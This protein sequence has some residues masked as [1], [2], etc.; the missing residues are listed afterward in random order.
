MTTHPLTPQSLALAAGLLLAL[1]SPS[2]AAAL[3]DGDQQADTDA[4]RDVAQAVT[5]LDAHHW[6]AARGDLENAETV[7]LNRESFDLG[8]TL[9]ASKPLPKTES[10][11][12]IDTARAAL[13]ARNTTRARDAATRANQEIGAELGAEQTVDGPNGSV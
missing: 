4:R 9:D 3:N 8:V 1:S 2:F 7:L 12:Q 10:M 11:T 6:R 5:Q 13:T